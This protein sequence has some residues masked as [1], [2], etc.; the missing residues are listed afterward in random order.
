M[1]FDML[2][3]KANL[4]PKCIVNNIITSGRFILSY[5]RAKKGIRAMKFKEIPKLDWPPD[6]K[7]F[8][9]FENSSI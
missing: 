7:F 1:Y 2:E 3:N 8:I 9:N 6:I 5:Q 4:F